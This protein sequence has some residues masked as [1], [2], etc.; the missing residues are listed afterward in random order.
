MDMWEYA[1][2]DE[3]LMLTWRRDDSPVSNRKFSIAREDGSVIRSVKDAT[4]NKRI[5]RS[6]HFRGWTAASP[7]SGM[8]CFH[9]GVT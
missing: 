6:A 2:L 3:G 7:R 4:G 9:A 1:K 8:K 5:A